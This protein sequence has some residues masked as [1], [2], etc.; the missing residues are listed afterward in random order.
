MMSRR[1]DQRDTPR[2]SG[3]SRRTVFSRLGSSDS[4]PNRKRP[5]GGY[6][7]GE[8]SREPYERSKYKRPRPETSKRRTQDLHERIRDLRKRIRSS[9]YSQSRASNEREKQRAALFGFKRLDRM[10][11]D[12]DTSVLYEM[13]GAEESLEITLNQTEIRRDVMTLL[14]QVLAKACRAGYRNV[15][16]RNTINVLSVVKTSD[17]LKKHL[18]Q[19]ISKIKNDES[20]STLEDTYR[21]CI[22]LLKSLLK[23]LPSTRDQVGVLLDLIT[24][25]CNT[26]SKHDKEFEH[27]KILDEI[28]ELQKHHSTFV[29]APE[30]EQKRLERLG[31]ASAI[32][33]PNDF[34]ECPIFPTL[35]ELTQTQ[36]PYLRRNVVNGKYRDLQHYLDVQFR[37]MR[38]DFVAPLREGVAQYQAGVTHSRKINDIRVYNKVRILYPVCASTGIVYKIQF[39][40]SSMR[41]IRWFVSKRLLYGSLLCL[42]TDNFQTAIFGTVANRDP[43]QLVEGKLDVDFKDDVRHLLNTNHEFTMVE[44]V[45]FF[46]A[47]RH[48]L[49]GLTEITNDSLPFQKHILKISPQVEPPQY[50]IN[51]PDMTFDLRALLNDDSH[52]DSQRAKSIR[53][54]DRQDWPSPGSIQLDQSQ[55]QAVYTALTSSFS[56][57]QGPPGT[58]KTHVGLKIMQVIL[59]NR[60]KW[61]KEVREHEEGEIDDE[62]DDLIDVSK[63]GPILVVCYTNHALDQF[64]EGVLCFNKNVVR[65]GGRSRSEQLDRYNLNQCRIRIRLKRRIE[66]RSLKSC[67]FFHRQEA[68]RVRREIEH[69]LGKLHKTYEGVLNGSLLEQY[70]TRDQRHRLPTRHI[71]YDILHWLRL[72][73]DF[74]HYA[75]EDELLPFET[76][77]TEEDLED[78]KLLDSGEFYGVTRDDRFDDI[79]DDYETEVPGPSN[80]IHESP[81]SMLVFDIREFRRKHRESDEDPTTRRLANRIANRIQTFV[82]SSERMSSVQA[83][84]LEYDI[85]DLQLDQRWNLYRYWVSRYRQQVFGEI[86]DKIDEYNDIITARKEVMDEE[87]YQI[88]SNADVIGMTTTRAAKSRALLQ[89]VKPKIVI[90]EEAAEILESHIVTTLSKHCKQLILIGDHQQLRPNPTVYRLAKDYNLDISL[91]ERMVKNNLP[92]QR[93]ALQHRMRPTISQLMKKHFY[94]DLQDHESVLQLDKVRGVCSNVF[95]IDHSHQESADN[96]T[97][98]RSNM[99]EARFLVALCRYLMQQDIEPSRITILTTYTGQL[100]NFKQLIKDGTDKSILGAVRVCV[101]DNYQG[102]ENDIILLSL[103]RSNDEGNIGFLKIANRVCVALS[104]AKKGL[105]CIGNFEQLSRQS[106]LWRKITTTMKSQNMLGTALTLAC[107]RHSDMKTDVSCEK[108][109]KHVP[110]GGCRQP[111]DFRLECG[112]VCDMPCHPYDPKHR[113]YQCKKPCAKTICKLEHACRKM[114]YEQCPR[115]CMVK[116]DKVLPSCGHSQ[117]IY[118]YS[119]PQF[120][121]CESKCSKTLTCGHPCKGLCG[122]PC[123]QTS[124][125]ELVK[126]DLPCGHSATLPCSTPLDACT[127]PCDAIL[128]CEHPCTGTCGGCLQGR[129]HKPCRKRCDRTL[130]CGHPCQEFCTLTCPPC[131]RPCENCCKHSKCKKRC[132]ELCVPCKE[133]CGWICKHAKCSKLCGDPC[134]REVC[135]EPCQKKC[136]HGR[137][138]GPSHPCIGICGEPCPKSCRIC[139]REEVTEVFFG[140]EEDSDAKFI[141]LEDCKH[142]IEVQGLDHWMNMADEGT[143]VSIQM[144]TCP[145]CKTPIRRSL[146]YGSIIKKILADIEK[147]KRKVQGDV[148]DRREHKEKALEELLNLEILHLDNDRVI[149]YNLTKK[150]R[151]RVEKW[152][153]YK[154]W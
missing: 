9:S 19:H 102:E 24:N 92:C 87:D 1:R 116:V 14:I 107:E 2:P 21:N 63:A 121:D 55:L 125:K 36:Q 4:H 12:D 71:Q 152:S 91:F 18:C 38:E 137:N 32:Q 69:I 100:L 65:V 3:A 42:S 101:V 13:A 50:L 84:R 25:A 39:D 124:C 117:R 148:Q 138:Q 135:N 68:S 110:E 149:D 146:R 53:L 30:E 16:P 143:S 11:K 96:D 97:R 43:K 49:E 17:F 111:C 40:C 104:R 130:V 153:V 10:S 136:S 113:K 72:D 15:A 90:I 89:R 108:D 134:D 119:N 82:E 106:E 132:G 20:S 85:L 28:E 54:L 95:F 142:L 103:V 66:D 8:S 147:V 51:N 29:D 118:C 79:D 154:S 46:E 70:M 61:E 5:H 120:V 31:Y 133:P 67:S 64:L 86:Q 73:N 145:K 93:L 141:E 27:Q 99:H 128:R 123:K 109:F 131:K 45:A 127:V 151:Q 58:V 48:V 7:Y 60:T 22:I 26:V 6:D 83:T 37:L 114:C 94:A 122:E 62:E 57:I 52:D 80:S 140:S 33:P 139:N 47:Y 35:E 56:V 115:T 76:E 98:S 88:L 78:G 74:H 112:H 34:R 44:S 77:T 23:H 144:K 41:K 75:S 59:K 126:R 105:Y 81:G 129:L 150:L